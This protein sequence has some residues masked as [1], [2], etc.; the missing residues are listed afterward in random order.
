M[1]SL[2]RG[3]DEAVRSNGFERL[4]GDQFD[5]E[6]VFAITGLDGTRDGLVSVYSYWGVCEVVREGRSGTFDFRLLT[7]DRQRA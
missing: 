6:T 2:D 3:K 1:M 4:D 5:W 7:C